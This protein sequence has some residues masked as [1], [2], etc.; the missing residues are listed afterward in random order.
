MFLFYKFDRLTQ[1]L[2]NWKF[3]KSKSDFTSI[4]IAAGVTK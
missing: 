1:K 2:Q 4:D 3:K